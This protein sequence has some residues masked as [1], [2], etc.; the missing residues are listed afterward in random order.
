MFK[1]SRP[2]W[3]S[4]LQTRP[5][6]LDEITPCLVQSTLSLAHHLSLLFPPTLLKGQA[7]PQQPG[8]GRSVSL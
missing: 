3:G 6:E 4:V 1:I 7:V 5:A 8:L 2:L